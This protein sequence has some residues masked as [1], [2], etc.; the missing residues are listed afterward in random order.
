L[1][2]ALMPYTIKLALFKRI[3]LATFA[4]TIIL[5]YPFIYCG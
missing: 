1:D 5:P 2:L 3:I 4:N